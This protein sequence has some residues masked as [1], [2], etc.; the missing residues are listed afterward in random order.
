MVRVTLH[1]FLTLN[2]TPITGIDMSEG[3]LHY[4]K[5][6]FSKLDSINLLESLIKNKEYELFLYLAKFIQ[7][8][9][10]NSELVSLKLAN[11]IDTQINPSEFVVG[12]HLIH[13]LPNNDQTVKKLRSLVRTKGIIGLTSSANFYKISTYDLNKYNYINHDF[14]KFYLEQLVEKV[15]NKYSVR[16]KLRSSK[17]KD[18]EETIELFQKNGFRLEIYDEF[19][20]PR[21]PVDIII[22]YS[23]MVVPD[24][25]GVFDNVNISDSDRETLIGKVLNGSLLSHSNLF[26]ADNKISTDVNTVFIFKVV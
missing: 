15:E 21:I 11:I 1:V 24:Y 25:L 8:M 10:N 9:K 20:L 4:A 12:S 3:M 7:E 19:P 23:L 6:K 14:V 26:D 16:V 13:W 18:P 22:T 17:T 5:L 2:N